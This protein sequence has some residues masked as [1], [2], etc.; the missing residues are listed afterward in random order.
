MPTACAQYIPANA[1]VTVKFSPRFHNA[2][3]ILEK[4]LYD[5]K[6][7]FSI[8][9]LRFYV[10]GIELYKNNKGVWKEANSYHLIDMEEPE[11]ME[12]FLTVPANMHY[13]HILFNLGIDSATN[14]AGAGSG[15]LEA[16]KGMYWAWQSGYVN[17]KL[18]GVHSACNTRKHEFE[19]HLGGFRGS[20]Y[21]M[22]Q[23]LLPAK[24]AGTITIAT[25]VAAFT[26]KIDFKA[27]NT[28]MTPGKEAVMLSK[29]A[30]AMFSTKSL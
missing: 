24:E 5:G 12:I 20:D 30:V 7:S 27:Q 3:L 15:D 9:T 1:G 18:E 25:D 14:A 21:C 4:K 16:T 11:S 29:K 26:N 17:F 2:P 13:D 23:V 8:N 19:F 28:V 10:S 22:Q 6:D